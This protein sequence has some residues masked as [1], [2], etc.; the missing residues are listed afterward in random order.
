MSEDNILY[1]RHTPE[2]NQLMDEWWALVRDYSQRDQL[3]LTYL[4]WRHDYN[5]DDL[6]FANPRSDLDNYYFWTHQHT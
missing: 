6:T 2:I 3:S 1:R 4:L 5:L